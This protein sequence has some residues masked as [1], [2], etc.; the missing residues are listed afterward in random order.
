MM[1]KILKSFILLLIPISLAGQLTPVTSQYVLNPLGI[2]P[3]Y[4]GN[5]GAL[6]IAAFYRRQWA[7]I[8]GAPETMTLAADSPFLDSK[9]GLGLIIASDKIGVTKETHFLTNYSYKISMKKGILSFGLGAGLLTTNTKWSDLVV[10]DPGDENLLTNSRVFVIPDFSFGIYYSYQNYFGGFSIPKLLGYRFNFNK[11]KYTLIFSPGQYNYLLNGGYIYTLS[12]KIKLFPSTL[13]TFSPK[14]KLLV[15]LNAYVSYIDRIWVGASYR[16]K[17]SLGILFQY[18]VN[19]Q[20]RIAYTYDIDFGKLSNYSNGSHEI[21][22][23]YEFH[24]RVDAIS[25]LNF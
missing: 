12:Q 24:Y 21:M 11:N 10:L 14:E 6:N 15:D 25:P 18:A 20:F 1:K 8:S 17:R 4:A 13:I 2:N 16:N 19:N 3:A 5:R 22:L 23:R 7:G 9:L